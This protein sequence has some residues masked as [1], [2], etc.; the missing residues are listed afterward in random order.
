MNRM[1]GSEILKDILKYELKNKGIFYQYK[2]YC[3]IFVNQLLKTPISERNNLTEN[4]CSSIF[5][6]AYISEPFFITKGEIDCENYIWVEPYFKFKRGVII[7][8]FYE[9]RLIIK[10]DNKKGITPARFFCIRK[11]YILKNIVKF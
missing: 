10:I 3:S 2:L 7:D 4:F 1:I 6:S 9:D 8:V 5:K 11:D